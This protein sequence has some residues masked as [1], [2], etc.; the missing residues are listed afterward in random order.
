M[1]RPIHHQWSYE[2]NEKLI[3]ERGVSFEEIVFHIDRGD[4][5]DIVD[6]PNYPNQR[7]YIIRIGDYAYRVPFIQS[8]STAFLKTIYP[9]RK[10]TREYLRNE[11]EGHEQGGDTT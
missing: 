6:N 5:L 7:V 11:G 4:V 1:S 3:R 10:A 9:S 8:E 2:K